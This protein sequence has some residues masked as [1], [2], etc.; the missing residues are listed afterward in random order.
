MSGMQADLLCVW[1]KECTH[2]G[3]IYLST[4]SRYFFLVR[5]FSA[6]SPKMALTS[7]LFAKVT[8]VYLDLCASANLRPSPRRTALKGKDYLLE[9]RTFPV[10]CQQPCCS[11][12]CKRVPLKSSFPLSSAPSASQRT[13]RLVQHGN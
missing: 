2:S 1:P 6:M 13:P 3:C 9:A 7:S 4:K 8:S 5:M 11:R 10:C 12:Q